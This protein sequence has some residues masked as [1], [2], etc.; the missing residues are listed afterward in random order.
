MLLFDIGMELDSCCKF[1]RS[2]SEDCPNVLSLLLGKPPPPWFIAG[3]WRLSLE[4]IGGSIES[5]FISLESWPST[6]VK[7]FLL[8]DRDSFRMSEEKK[9]SLLLVKLTPLNDFIPVSDS[10]SFTS[11]NKCTYSR[12][13]LNVYFLGFVRIKALPQVLVIIELIEFIAKPIWWFVFPWCL[14]WRNSERVFISGNL[15][16]VKQGFFLYF[17]S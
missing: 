7:P 6:F 10:F 14:Q 11:L 16:T 5:M 4:F 9:F 3:R 12:L 13:V 2:P 15:W 17:E 8:D 1:S